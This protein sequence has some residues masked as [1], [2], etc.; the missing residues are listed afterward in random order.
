ME[1]VIVKSLRLKYEF[2][3]HDFMC[4]S[5]NRGQAWDAFRLH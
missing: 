2:D 5:D 1:S 3:V 4:P